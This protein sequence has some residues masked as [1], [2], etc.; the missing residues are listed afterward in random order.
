MGVIAASPRLSYVFA[1]RFCSL[2]NG[3]EVNNLGLT[4]VELDFVFIE[5]AVADQFQMQL[6]HPADDG[7]PPYGLCFN[8]NGRVLLDKI[9]QRSWK[10][11]EV[12]IAPRTDGHRYYG[13]V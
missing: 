8:S 6:A 12:I 4:N 13:A 1:F 7:L 5:D 10:L 9:A 2:A 11:F 3:L